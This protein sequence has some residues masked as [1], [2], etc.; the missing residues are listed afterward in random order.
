FDEFY[1]LPYPNDNSKYH[2]TL[3]K[4]M[5]PLPLIE[6]DAPIAFDPEQ[7]QFTKSFTARSIRFLEA[8]RDRPFFLYLAHVMPHVP[9]FASERFKG[10]TGHGLYAD[11]INELDWSMGEIIATL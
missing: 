4:E 1:G 8:N 9:I 5:P 10:K 11:V 7:S 3:A 6:G 2:P